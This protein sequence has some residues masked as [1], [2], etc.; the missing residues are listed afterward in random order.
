MGLSLE[1]IA[2]RLGCSKAMV[3]RLRRELRELGRSQRGHADNHALLSTT[4][5]SPSARRFSTPAR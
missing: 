1:V 2:L 4:A 3:S 5:L